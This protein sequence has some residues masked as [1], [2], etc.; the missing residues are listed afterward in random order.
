MRFFDPD[1]EECMRVGVVVTF[2]RMDRAPTDPA[3][4]LPD[5]FT[6][7]KLPVCSVAQYRALYNMVGGPW[8]W[9]LRRLMPDRDL[10]QHLSR[11]AIS[12]YVAEYRGEVVGFYELDAGQWP[13][14]NLSY[15]GLMPQAIGHG[16]GQAFL[17]HA[18]D[19]AWAMKARAVTVNTCT[20][21]HPRAL[22]NYKRVG[23]REV[24]AVEEMWDIPRKL[25]LKKPAH[26][27]S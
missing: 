26:M 3:P 24:R 16:F 15:F 11:V 20:A 8:L 10:A 27:S 2:L 5:G 25:G 6:V 4:A 1:A 7:R 21:D 17:R 9:W 23:F 19:A 13:S 14:M 18:V 22:P 12:I